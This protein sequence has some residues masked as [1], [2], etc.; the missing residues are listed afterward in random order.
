MS[1]AAQKDM[2]VDAFLAW[3]EGRTRQWEVMMAPERALHALAEYEAKKLW[4]P[5]SP[6]PAFRAACFPTG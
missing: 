3:A 1:D 4:R 5:A 6:A 2:D